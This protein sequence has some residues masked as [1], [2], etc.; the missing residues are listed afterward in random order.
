MER[1]NSDSGKQQDLERSM[2]RQ[3][4]RDVLQAMRKQGEGSTVV[5]CKEAR[6]LQVA[7][8]KDVVE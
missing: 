4:A 5:R 8:N 1:R 6:A 7:L 2:W 3:A